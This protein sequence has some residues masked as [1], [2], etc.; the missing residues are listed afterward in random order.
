MRYEHSLGVPDLMVCPQCDLL[1]GDADEAR[2]RRCSIAC[3][4]CSARLHRSSDH[5]GLENVL[6]LACAALVLLVLA[7]A[8]P[9][10]GLDVNGQRSEATLL[11]AIT[12]L[13][14]AQMQPVAVLVLLTTIVAPLLELSTILWLVLPLWLGRRPRAFIAVIRLL[15]LARP[16]AMT[17]VFMLGMLVAMVKLAHFADLLP[18][19]GIWSFGGLMLLL[20]AL[21]VL[22]EP[23]DLWRT[24]EAARP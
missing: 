3:P 17:E 10:L 24:W 11:D 4:R 1:L 23:R 16:W 13:W 14:Q 9:V 15:N 21:T 18:G 19:I 20:T 2:N 22:T 12:K 8:F 5:G 6:A 7:N